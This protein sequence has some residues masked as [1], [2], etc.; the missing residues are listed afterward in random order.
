MTVKVLSSWELAWNCPIKEEEQWKFPLK[1]FSVD[2]LIMF[3]VTGIFSSYTVE[4]TTYEECVAANQGLT[5]VFVDEHETGTLHDYTHPENALY[6]FG[7]TSLSL[8][9]V[10]KQPGDHSIKIA[11]PNDTVLLLGH[12][13]ATLVLHDRYLN[14]INV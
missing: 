13:D 9:T 1:E 3:P 11:N 10:Y 7:K 2:E 6:V 8:S 14:S 12:Q 5:I 4:Y